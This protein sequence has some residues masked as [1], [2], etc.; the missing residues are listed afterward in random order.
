MKAR[1]IAKN[2]GA[3]SKRLANEKMLLLYESLARRVT[4]AAAVF[5]DIS[6]GEIGFRERRSPHLNRA[7]SDP[8]KV[9]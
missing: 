6:F 8:V 3:A 7:P 1:H 2:K 4:H 9:W 5:P